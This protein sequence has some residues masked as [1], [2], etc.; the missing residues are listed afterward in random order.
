MSKRWRCWRGC[1]R[2]CRARGVSGR[3]RSHPGKASPAGL[4]SAARDSKLAAKIALRWKRAIA[5]NNG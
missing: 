1:H 3:D 5:C 4:R 2:P